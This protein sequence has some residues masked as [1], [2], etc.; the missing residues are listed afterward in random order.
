[1]GP[2]TDQPLVSMRSTR[3]NPRGS[4]PP[5]AAREPPYS[6]RSAHLSVS[7][8]APA[9]SV[10]SPLPSATTAMPA[11]RSPAAELRFRDL[12]QLVALALV[13]LGQFGDREHQQMPGAGRDDDAVARG[14]GDERGLQDCA[15]PFDVDQL[16]AGLLVR[17]QRI[18]AR[19][20]AVAAIGRDDELGRRIGDR[21]RI[22]ARAGRRRE[23]AGQR[24][25]VAARG[26]QRVRRASNSCGRSSR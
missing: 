24:L 10:T 23:A 25:A 3:C 22:E 5:R 7:L 20:E 11:T 13:E 15:P 19:H 2:R 18:E 17:E 4:K 14:I 6:T 8:R 12:D 26:R 21:D 1:M 9:Y 16:L